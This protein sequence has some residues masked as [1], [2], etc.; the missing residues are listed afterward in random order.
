MNL[1][2]SNKFNTPQKKLAQPKTMPLN[3]KEM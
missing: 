2:G 1:M 3:P